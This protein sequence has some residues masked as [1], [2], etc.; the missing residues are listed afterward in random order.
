MRRRALTFLALSI[1]SLALPAQDFHEFRAIGLVPPL[2]LDW[3]AVAAGDLD[4]DGHVDLVFANFGTPG[5]GQRNIWMRNDGTGLFARMPDTALRL[6]PSLSHAVLLA[7]FD[8]DGDL[9]AFFGNQRRDAICRNDG[10][11]ELSHAPGDLPALDRATY[12]AAA[13]DVDRDGDL[14]IVAACG[15]YDIVYVNDGAG[16]FSDGSAR[17]PSAWDLTVALEL[18]DFDS[19]GDLDLL[20]VNQDLPSQLLLNDGT[21]RFADSGL[22]LP[23]GA[24]I[25]S[26]DVDRD[27]RRDFVFGTYI[28]PIMMPPMYDTVLYRNVGGLAFATTFLPRRTTREPLP[29]RLVDLDGDGDLDLAIAGDRVLHNDGQGNFT[30]GAEQTWIGNTFADVDGDGDP[31]LIGIPTL[32]NDGLGGF[33]LP[34]HLPAVSGAEGT[35]ALALVDFDRDGDLDLVRQDQGRLEVLG[36][37]GRGA[38]RGT[39]ATATNNTWSNLPWLA[40]DWTGDGYPDLIEGHSGVLFENLAGQGLA[41]RPLPEPVGRF[42][43]MDVDGDADL[44]LV[45]QRSDATIAWYRNDGRGTFAPGLA[46]P[47]ARAAKLLAAADVDGDARHDLLVVDLTGQVVLLRCTGNGV[48]TVAPGAFPAGVP[49]PVDAFLGDLDGD[50]EADCAFGHDYGANLAPRV[51][52]LRNDGTGRFTVMAA[53]VPPQ[54]L[55]RVQGVVGADLDDDGDIDLVASAST[56]VN[57]NA[58]VLRND[59]GFAFVDVTGVGEPWLGLPRTP[60]YALPGDIDRDGDVDIVAGLAY[61]TRVLHNLQRQLVVDADPSVGGNW[62]IAAAQRPIGAAAAAVLVGAELTPPLPTPF[63]LL[64]V[65]LNLAFVS[66]LVPIDQAAPQTVITL[67]VPNQPSLRGQ[68]IFV[69]NV[70]IDGNAL[71]LGNLLRLVVQ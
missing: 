1:T 46:L 44:D 17:L 48:F 12:A 30:A 14:D 4:R 9:D 66:G 58:R 11:G 53:V 26:G 39:L 28:P 45:G 27:G 71:R 6:G 10:H 65:D 40:A 5:V 29:G 49:P 35:R 60:G 59:G 37:D 68:R 54:V 50:G 70:A 32:R 55:V 52:L 33:G 51:T 64:R 61:G 3:R 13:G 18:A 38:F 23:T 21:G 43:S 57:E 63:G 7:D 15:G 31:D 69:Q 62:R 19:D 56:F 47:I 36:N 34:G 42:V 2:E 67:P 24:S 16:V 8:R 20:R 25:S 41:T 22:V